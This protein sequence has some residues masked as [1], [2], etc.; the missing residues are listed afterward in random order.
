MNDKIELRKKTLLKLEELYDKRNKLI[1]QTHNLELEIDGCL[2]IINYID[3]KIEVD[4]V[5]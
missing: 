5:D 4:E 3:E 1:K 2:A